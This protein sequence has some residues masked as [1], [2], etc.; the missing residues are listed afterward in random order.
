MEV[1]AF[2]CD[3]ACLCLSR[4]VR[5]S[6]SV[7]PHEMPTLI[8]ALRARCPVLVL[9][10]LVLLLPGGA[11]AGPVVVEF[12]FPL[13]YQD[14]EFGPDLG[15]ARIQSGGFYT[16]DDFLSGPSGAFEIVD[17]LFT[18][19]SGP[20]MD[21]TPDGGD[22]VYTHAAGG[23]LSVAFSLL[24]PGGSL[25]HGTF[26]APLGTFVVR[27]GSGGNTSG[28]LGPGVFDQVTAQLLGISPHTL[29]S[30]GGASLFLDIYDSY[31]DGYRVAKAF[32]YMEVA[33]TVPEPALW[34][35]IT[36]GGVA[37]SLR[38]RRR[39]RA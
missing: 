31:P 26:T 36:T 38:F 18:L 35:L 13:S 24:L 30:P 27:P 33:A 3:P 8:N 4:L 32:G 1:H 14:L 9:G 7:A 20:L 5:L 29:Q 2:G 16:N 17:G 12:G 37:A 11:H 21:V 19:E 15:L 22:A 28:D 25:H 34:W 39:T 6:D 23:L 10:L